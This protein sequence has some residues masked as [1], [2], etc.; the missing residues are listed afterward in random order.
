LFSYSWKVTE[1]KK[2]NYPSWLIAS[3]ALDMVLDLATLALPLFV[4][5]TLQ[6]SR[7]KKFVV[8]GIFAL[9]TL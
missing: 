3:G 5:R 1:Q 4:I 6:M 7:R 2:I 8:S 9:G